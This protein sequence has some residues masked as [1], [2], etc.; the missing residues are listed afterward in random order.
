KVGGRDAVQ[1]KGQIACV[2]RR[3]LDGLEQPGQLFRQQ[4]VE[5]AALAAKIV[6]QGR[7]CD[8]C[9]IDDLLHAHRV[10]ATRGEQLQGAG[11]DIGAVVHLSPTHSSD[12]WHYTARYTACQVPAR[13]FLR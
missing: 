10:I 1:G 9:R 2:D 4:R 8:A 12:Q 13:L 3:L 7:F 5:Q 6:V 11:Q